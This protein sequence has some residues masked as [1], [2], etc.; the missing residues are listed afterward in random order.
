MITYI[1]KIVSDFSILF[2]RLQRSTSAVQRSPGANDQ[3]CPGNI[4]TRYRKHSGGKPLRRTLPANL[5]IAATAARAH[6]ARGYGEYQPAAQPLGSADFWCSS[7]H[8]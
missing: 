6:R 2:R 1:L 3:R 5:S 8:Y 7:H 4:P